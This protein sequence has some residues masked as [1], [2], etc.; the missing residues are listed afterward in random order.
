M[1]KITMT[2]NNA[3]MS[4]EAKGNR[5][6]FFMNIILLLFFSSLSLSPTDIVLP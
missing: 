6:V 4:L 2:K 3:R 1:K 5:E